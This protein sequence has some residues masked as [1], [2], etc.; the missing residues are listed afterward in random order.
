MIKSVS[1]KFEKL[2][3][4]TGKAILICI[5]GGEHWTDE[6]LRLKRLRKIADIYKDAQYSNS[7]D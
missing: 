2:L 3:H 6:L 7:W 1:L 5:N 4:D